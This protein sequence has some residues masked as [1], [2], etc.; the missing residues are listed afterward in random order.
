VRAAGRIDNDWARAALFVVAAVALAAIH[1]RGAADNVT[2]ITTEERHIRDVILQLKR[3]RPDPPAG[4]RVL[5]V[6]D[7]FEGRVWDS[8]FLLRLLYRDNGITV[9]RGADRSGVGNYDYIWTFEEGKLLE[10]RGGDRKKG[11]RVRSAN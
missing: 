10:A 7:P 1:T 4:S 3:M 11:G 6:K 5:F 9:D 8:T 2:W